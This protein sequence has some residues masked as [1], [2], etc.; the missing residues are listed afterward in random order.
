M[1][2]FMQIISFM[3]AVRDFQSIAS[4]PDRDILGSGNVVL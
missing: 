4:F 3:S 1:D 2:V